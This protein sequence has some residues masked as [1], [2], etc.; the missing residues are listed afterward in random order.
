MSGFALTIR[1]GDPAMMKFAFAT[2][3]SHLPDESDG[4]YAEA[5]TLARQ[6]GFPAETC[7]VIE[8]AKLANSAGWT[9]LH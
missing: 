5:L 6:P 1:T 7:A 3:E 4:F 2:L 9:R 8:A